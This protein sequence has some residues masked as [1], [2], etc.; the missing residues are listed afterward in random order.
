L[1][2]A[3]GRSLVLLGLEE[4]RQHLGG[5]LSIPMLN[6]I[7]E[8]LDLHEIDAARM[9]QALKRLSALG[10]PALTLSEGCAQ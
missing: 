3:Q 2:D 1:K 7:G 6:R 9:E 8:S 10:D 5:E 4:F